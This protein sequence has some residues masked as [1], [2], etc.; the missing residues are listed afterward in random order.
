MKY[1]RKVTFPCGYS[2]ETSIKGGFFDENISFSDRDTPTV[3]PMHGNKC[4]VK[5]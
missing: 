3:C 1:F 4:K 2:V 5:K